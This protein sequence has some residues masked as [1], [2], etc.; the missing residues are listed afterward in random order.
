MKVEIVENF[1]VWVSTEPGQP[2]RK[3]GFTKGM[4]VDEPNV[5]AGQSAQ[6]WIDKGLAK[7]VKAAE[8]ERD[9]E[10]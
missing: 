5:P 8:G 7:A 1:R 9:A 6:D 2:E 10:V 3:V 4:V